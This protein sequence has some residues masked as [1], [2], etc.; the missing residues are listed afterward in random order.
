MVAT[1]G[2]PFISATALVLGY[3]SLSHFSAAFAAY[4]EVVIVGV[5][6]LWWLH[7]SQGQVVTFHTTGKTASH[8]HPQPARAGEDASADAT[9]SELRDRIR[10]YIEAGDVPQ[11][12]IE[13][14]QALDQGEIVNGSCFESLIF[15]LASA[16]SIEAAEGWVERFMEVDIEGFDQACLSVLVSACAKQG[17]AARA[18]YWFRKMAMGFEADL[19]TFNDMLGAVARCGDAGAAEAWLE[20]VGNYGVQ[21]DA[22]SYAS[23][24]GSRARAGET[25]RAEALLTDMRESGIQ[26]D[27]ACYDALVCACTEGKD[28]QRAEAWM[29]RM[30]EEGSEPVASSYSA[31]ISICAQAGDAKSAEYWLDRMLRAEVRPSKDTLLD[32]LQAVAKL[33]DPSRLD[34]FVLR[35][36]LAGQTCASAFFDAIAA[37]CGKDGGAT[38]MPLAEM[39][40]AKME[41]AGVHL[42]AASLSAMAPACAFEGHDEDA[43]KWV[44]RAMRTLA[45][46]ESQTWLD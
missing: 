7:A 16:G 28:Q 24:M 22:A 9:G 46:D 13:L 45:E 25:D 44:D 42:D 18:E 5:L 35:L 41:A 36:E 15:E 29:K 30:I 21:P 37:A 19:E 33:D 6:A 12:E 3:C 11:A 14:Q 31:V 40:Y 43:E 32:V 2:I 17:H 1:A 39:W 4:R 23:V 10:N 38:L 20:E 27:A 26:P 8:K 34:A